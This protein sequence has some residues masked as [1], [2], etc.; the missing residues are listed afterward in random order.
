[1]CLASAGVST[2]LRTRS[3]SA[4]GVERLFGYGSNPILSN[5]IVGRDLGS[6]VPVYP[7]L[8]VRELVANALIHQKF[9][10][11]GAGPMIEIFSDRIEVTNPG[12]PLVEP[13][14]FLDKP[15]RSRNESLASS[16]RR[17][18]VCEERGSGV[19][20]VVLQT[21]L[22]Q[23]PAP[24]F[25]VVGDNT[26]AS[27]FAP[28]PLNKMMKCTNVRALGEH[29]RAYVFR[30]IRYPRVSARVSE[31]S[32][33][34]AMHLDLESRCPLEETVGIAEYSP[35]MLPHCLI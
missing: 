24:K 16:M 2:H 13:G 12:E 35:Y 15:P 5:K 10:V 4:A 19:D 18:G 28:K 34:R 22:Y 23:L 33:S 9:S 20:K 31:P 14:R 6:D 26:R 21:E 1:M 30:S 27:L 7:E 8:V 32:S 17:I 25:E 29:K 3:G 11:R